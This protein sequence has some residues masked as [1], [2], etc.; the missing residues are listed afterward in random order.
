MAWTITPSYSYISSFCRP[1]RV[2]LGKEGYSLAS[3]PS[4][5]QAPLLPL[6]PTA[7]LLS[8][9]HILFLRRSRGWPQGLRELVSLVCAPPPPAPRPVTCTAPLPE[10]DTPPGGTTH[11][12]A[13]LVS[14]A[15]PSVAWARW[16]GVLS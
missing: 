3:L 14:L 13:L 1:K 7:L 4:P 11:P 16:A 9:T 8:E 5:P 6:L 10:A 2:T 15:S 12:A